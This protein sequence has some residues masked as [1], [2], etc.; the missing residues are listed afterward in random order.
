MA[1]AL[2]TADAEGRPSARMVLLRRFDQRGFI[3]FTNSHSKKGRELA[4]NPRAALC[5]YWDELEEQVRVQGA[6]AQVSDP[7]SNAYWRSRTRE[8]QIGA[9]ASLQSEKLDDRAT[10]EARNAE[11]ERQFA[12]Q[13]VPRP[14]HWYGYRVA[15]DSIEFWKNR[16]ARLHERL[17]YER[18]DNGWQKRLLYP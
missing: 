6:V 10:L 4:A 9:W 8:S 7:E 18:T 16:P 15:P 17:I 12:N 5:F 3:F 14:E 2:A 1:V 13:N 11:F